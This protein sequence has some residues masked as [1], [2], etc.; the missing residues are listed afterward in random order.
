[1]KLSWKQFRVFGKLVTF[2]AIVILVQQ[3][4]ADQVEQFRQYKAGMSE[5]PKCHKLF[6]GRAGLSFI[7]HLQDV[8]H[9]ESGASMDIVSEL[10]RKL[11]HRNETARAAVV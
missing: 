10:Y 1:M 11:L 3:L 7:M 9:V 5:C 2:P 6:D 4:D 8:H